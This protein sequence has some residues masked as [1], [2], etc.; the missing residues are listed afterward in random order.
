MLLLL[1]V[2]ESLFNSVIAKTASVGFPGVEN[3]FRRF[4]LGL[5]PVI[6]RLAWYL[7]G[8]LD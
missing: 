6:F 3:L 5:G 8:I 2:N 7:D 1:V 4:G